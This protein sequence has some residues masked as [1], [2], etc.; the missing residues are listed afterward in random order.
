ME[1]FISGGFW[2]LEGILTSLAFVGLR[3]WLKERNIQ[4]NAWK[5]ILVLLWVLFFGFTIAFVT[6]SLGERE[7]VAAFKGALFFGIIAMIALVG[8]WCLLGLSGKKGE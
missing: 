5:W 1:F 4:M 7:R 3:I 6:T 8:L 2:F